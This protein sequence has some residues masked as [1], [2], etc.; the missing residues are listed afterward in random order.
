MWL[1]GALGVAAALVELGTREL[2]AA[3]RPEVYGLAL[4]VPTLAAAVGWW[5]LRRPRSTPT[6]QTI[7]P[8]LSLAVLPSTL[9]LLDDTT[10]RW[11]YGEDPGTAYQV[12]MV[13]LLAIGV[14]AAVVGGWRRWSGLFFPGLALTVVVVAIQLVELGRFLPQWVSFAIAGALLIAAGAR[15]E[16]VRDRGRVGA[17]WVRRLH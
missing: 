8:V 1:G 5:W 11:W 16:W 12:R 2:A 7:G 3:T 6:W 13:V 9:A 14:V 10:N 4:G 17:A 15:W